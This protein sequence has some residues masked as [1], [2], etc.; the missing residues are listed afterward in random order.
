M[1]Q[2]DYCSGD[3]DILPLKSTIKR[4]MDTNDYETSCQISVDNS[5]KILGTLKNLYEERQMCD[6]V[7]TVGQKEYTAHR[8]ILCASSDVFQA[9]LMK[10]EWS[11]WHESKIA[12]QELPQCEAVFHLF[13]E[14]FYTGK[15]VITHT[16]VMPILALA[17][18]YMVKSLTQVCIKYMSKHIAHAASHNQLFSWL[19]Y[20]T[21]CG[22]DNVAN[23]CQNYIKWNFESVANT[24]DFSNFETDLLC[25]LLKQSDIVV[26]N[27]MV[28]YNCVV[29]WLDLQ[30]IRY[31]QM[32]LSDTEMQEL[33][34]NIVQCVMKCIR[35]PMM[36]PRELADLL[37]SPLMKRYSQSML[38]Y[39]A[40]GMLFQKGRSDEID[41][42]CS[43]DKGRILCTPRLYTCDTFNT[44]LL[45]E[46][47][48]SIPS[49]NVTTLVFSTR[50]SAAEYEADK[51]SEWVVDL[52]PKGVCFKKC[53]LIV[54]QGT[55]EVPERVKSTIRL[56]LTCREFKE[57]MKC[58]VGVLLY[59]TQGGIEHIM[60]VKQRVH[61]FNSQYPV[62][63][64]D[65]LIPFE[66][67]N[68]PAGEVFSR[69]LESDPKPKSMFLT[70]CRRDQ[71]K[72]N[73]II[74]PVFSN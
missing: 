71:L 4:N 43:T 53:Y 21:T 34:V 12:L 49:Y 51:I 14:Y 29:R 41:N 50:M 2:Q 70:G 32:K 54:W 72:I 64:I 57:D 39:M 37:L 27:E 11:E 61:H 45:I 47:V 66:E 58:N 24:P 17:D 56:S 48:P 22:Y 52:Y 8:L 26:Y 60:Q 36:S 25:D 20:T 31:N 6:V 23:L 15:I 40:V 55:L 62:L 38:E 18:K 16:N 10:P 19:Q 13:L 3:D 28:L 59:G 35:F 44:T 42:F 69:S 63:V 74:T 65:N 30:E 68:P 33:M 67:L 9:M 73:I 7:I 46:N 5:Q 1:L